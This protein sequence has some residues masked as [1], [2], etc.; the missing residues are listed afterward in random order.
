MIA[1]KTIAPTIIRPPPIRSERTSISVSGII[2]LLLS[3][4]VTSRGINNIKDPNINI[5]HTNKLAD[6][7][8]K[9]FFILCNVLHEIGRSVISIVI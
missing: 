1:I 5:D 2:R 9:N 4:N 7:L 3:H 6:K 8:H